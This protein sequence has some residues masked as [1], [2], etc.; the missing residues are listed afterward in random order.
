MD[1]GN[2]KYKYND[3]KFTYVTGSKRKAVVAGPVSKPGEGQDVHDEDQTLPGQQV[4][5][6]LLR[7]PN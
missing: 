7:S 6:R 3:F 1:V 5:Q 4:H 2:S